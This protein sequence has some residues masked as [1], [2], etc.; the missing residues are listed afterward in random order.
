MQTVRESFETL[1][2]WFRPEYAAGISLTVEYRITGDGGGVWHAL[3][4][5]NVCTV[6]EGPPITDSDMTV[7]AKAQD[8]LDIVSGKQLAAE[9]PGAAWLTSAPEVFFMGRR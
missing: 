9:R 4:A 3:V 7:N 8:W 6:G 5:D 1:E 2:Q